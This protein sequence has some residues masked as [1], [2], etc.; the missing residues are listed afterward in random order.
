MRELIH[1][2]EQVYPRTKKSLLKA[3]ANVDP[4]H[5]LDTRLTRRD[6]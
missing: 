6:P 3:M 4:V 1:Q 5:L 2:M